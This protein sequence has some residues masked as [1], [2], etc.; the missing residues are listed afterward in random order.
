MLLVPWVVLQ[1]LDSLKSSQLSN[2]VKS[3][4]RPAVDYIYT[5]LKNQE[6]RVWGQ[7]MQQ[8]S[9]AA[10]KMLTFLFVCV[11]M[12]AAA[13][14]LMAL[15]VNIVTGGL[16][17]VNNDDRVLQCCLQYKALYPEGTVMLCT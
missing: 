16:N 15:F 5:A 13:H 12:R 11:R 17:T 4:A 7:S 8:M 14:Q 2:N 3:K 1:E 9:L 10:C 6:P